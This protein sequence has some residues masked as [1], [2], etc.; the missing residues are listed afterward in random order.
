M[1]G[2]SRNLSII[3]G[4]SAPTFKPSPLNCR[5]DGTEGG[6]EGGSG[7]MYP[8]PLP[9]WVPILVLIEKRTDTGMKSPS[10]TIVPPKIV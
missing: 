1:F 4:K 8:F 5:A 7:G 2:E 10:F 6:G 9:I 3:N